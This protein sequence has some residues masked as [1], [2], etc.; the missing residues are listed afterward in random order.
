MRP[1]LH[2]RPVYRIQMDFLDR[3]SEAHMQH[4]H[5]ILRW[6]SLSLLLLSVLACHSNTEP[7]AAPPASKTLIQRV[8]AL[9]A[10]IRPAIPNTAANLER[11]AKGFEADGRQALAEKH[12]RLALT[13][14]ESAWGD[15]HP[16][17]V[18]SL[19]ALAAYYT[20]QGRYT[21]AEALWQ[22]ALAIKE[23]TLSPHHPDVATTLAKYAV[24]LHKM[25]R[26]REALALEQRAQAIQSK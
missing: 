8:Q 1:P 13:I 23:K 20:T 17:V 9:I 24:L 12:Y 5:F 25:G 26:E 3:R 14:R 10:L 4:K 19:E 15:E 7:N 22:R 6:L 2:H 21:D 11:L 16:N 18:P